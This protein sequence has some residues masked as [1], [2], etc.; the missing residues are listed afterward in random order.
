MFRNE[1]LIAI[2]G[3]KLFSGIETH[4]QGSDVWSEILHRGREVR[5]GSFGTE[6]GVRDI[7]AVTVRVAE[8]H[9]RFRCVIEFIRRTLITQH[10]AP[11]VGEPQLF[12]FRIPVES[13]RIAYP[14][15][16]DP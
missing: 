13:H 2:P 15:R 5:A 14:A 16:K 12:G 3:R 11:I 7:P 10:V 8:M 4:P 6:F 9:V 1:N